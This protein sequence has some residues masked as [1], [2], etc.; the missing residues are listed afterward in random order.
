MSKTADQTPDVVILA[1][2]ERASLHRA[3]GSIVPVWAIFAHLSIPRRSGAAR[4]VQQRLL[5]MQE[6][7]KV[8][9]HLTHGVKA[10]EITS[11]GRRYLRRAGVVELPESPQHAAWRNA[12]TLAEQEVERFEQELTGTLTAA[13]EL[14]ERESR[15]DAMFEMAR[16][17]LIEFRRLGSAI[18]CLRE[19]EE[20]TDDRPDLETPETPALRELRMGRRNPNGWRAA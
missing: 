1:A 8:A 9:P 14:V 16:R 12:R 13:L 11:S 10:W 20:P 2:I 17:L 19:W 5:A 4:H 3:R 15:S 18:Y 6:A 7:G